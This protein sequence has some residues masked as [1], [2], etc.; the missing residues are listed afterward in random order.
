MLDNNKLH[1]LRVAID[2]NIKTSAELLKE[3]LTQPEVFE[4]TS[5]PSRPAEIVL[6]KLQE[7]KMW[8]GKILEANGAPFPAELRDEAKAE[9]PQNEVN[10]SDEAPADMADQPA[11]EAEEAALE[12]SEAE[13]T[14]PTEPSAK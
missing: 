5:H 13:P 1:E 2:A 10:A 3:C 7:A 9:E 4:I 6:T 12:S 14:E 8:V 11:E